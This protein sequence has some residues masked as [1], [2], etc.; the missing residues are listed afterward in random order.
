[1]IRMNKK[2]SEIHQKRSLLINPVKKK[3]SDELE[4]WMIE[5]FFVPYQAS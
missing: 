1:M 4:S 5:E 3:D 2:V